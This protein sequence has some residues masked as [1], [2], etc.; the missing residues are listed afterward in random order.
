MAAHPGLSTTSQKGAKPVATQWFRSPLLP[1]R[2]WT[3]VAINPNTGCWEWTASKGEFGYGFFH[4]EGKVR[5]AHRVAFDALM[6]Y[7]PDEL[8]HYEC[9]NP[10]CVNPSHLRET[11]HRANALRNTSPMARNAAK[12]HCHKGHEFT[13]KNTYR[14]P[15]T[16]FRR[17]CRI[18]HAASMAKRPTTR[19]GRA[20]RSHAKANTAV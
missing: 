7:L 13:V 9:D 2:F 14:S 17:Q 16:P 19:A 10:P 11:T 6:G 3:K 20:A 8:D 18:C 1:E 4:I 12:T 5:L 15:S